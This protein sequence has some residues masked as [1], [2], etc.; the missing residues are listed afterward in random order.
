MFVDLVIF[1][2]M[3]Y[4]YKPSEKFWANDHKKNEDAEENDKKGKDNAALDR[5]E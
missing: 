3:A 2:F 5:S 1:A 4:R